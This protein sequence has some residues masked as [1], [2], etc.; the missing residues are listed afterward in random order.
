MRFCIFLYIPKQKL[1]NRGE[2][3]R[4]GIDFLVR[5][6]TVEHVY[7][8]GMTSSPLEAVW[9]L[10][11]PTFLRIYR[12]RKPQGLNRHLNNAFL[13][14]IE[15]FKKTSAPIARHQLTEIGILQSQ[16]GGKL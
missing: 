1:I 12:N 5:W 9:R 8:H 10:W 13:G 4:C 2:G 15:R 11:D 16:Q 14:L 6:A 3:I 7:K